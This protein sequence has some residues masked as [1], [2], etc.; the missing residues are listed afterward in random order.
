MLSDKDI[1]IGCIHHS[2]SAQKEL[3]Q[4]Y[5]P[6]MKSICLRYIG[7]KEEVKDVL[8]EA[9]V[10]IFLNIK[11]YSEKGSFEGWIKRIVINTTISH[12]RKNKKQ[13]TEISDQTLV[14]EDS[15]TEILEECL[16]DSEITEEII[17]EC[18]DGLPQDFKMVFNLYYL[19]EYSHKEISKVL[20]IKEETSRSRLLRA[21]RLLQH[22]LQEKL[23][24][25]SGSIKQ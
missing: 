22:Q 13:F 5:A 25:K 11:S 7:D 14:S 21:R 23:K 1:V 15:D 3:Y 18:L 2:P 10:K 20:S 8:Q 24:I 19:E 9:F 6:K 17:M 12:L 16:R 4:K